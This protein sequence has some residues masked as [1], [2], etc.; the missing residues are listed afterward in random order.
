MDQLKAWKK[1]EIILAILINLSCIAIYVFA[2]Y[3]GYN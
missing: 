3:K 2:K 1:H